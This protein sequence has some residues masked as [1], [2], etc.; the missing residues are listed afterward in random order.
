MY[1]T[2]LV[3][4]ALSGTFPLSVRKRYPK[5]RIVCGEFFPYFKNHLRK[6]GFEVYD[7][8]EIVENNMEF[9]LVIGN[10]PYQDGNQPIW[11]DFTDKAFKLA[12]VV[13]FVTPRAVLNGN[14]DPTSSR[15]RGNSYFEVM[16]S[17]LR[18]VDYSADNHFNVGKRIVAW[19]Y[20][21]NY[22]GP[23]KVIDNNDV[24]VDM[25]LST[26][27]YLPYELTDTALR[28]F[29]R[30]I[31]YPEHMTEFRIVNDERKP[32]GSFLVL[33]KSKHLSLNKMVYTPDLLNDERITSKE[34]M[35]HPATSPNA[36]TYTS[37]NIY[38]YMFRILG[39]TDGNTPILLRKIPKVDLT[40]AWT[41]EELYKHF[42]VSDEDIAVIEAAVTP[43][44]KKN[45][46]SVV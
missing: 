38:K 22:T 23:T 14:A 5:A 42:G 29:E 13:A 35:I 36:E 15:S 24:E 25:D 33:P 28:M 2:I 1:K 43:K 8:N 46:E 32:D 39:G 11:K 10:P 26:R 31:A 12:P 34:M 4:N 3:V 21:Q 19:I 40:K 17:N 41:N 9:D 44:S 7:W 6:L 45:S 20:D 18:L 30:M 27:Y 16:R 37:S